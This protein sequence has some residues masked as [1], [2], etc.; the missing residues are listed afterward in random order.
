MKYVIVYLIKG[1]AKRYHEGLIKEV[2]P[3]FGENYIIENPIPSHIT[4]KS[5]FE[6]KSINKLEEILKDFTKKYK[7]SK[8]QIDGFGNFKR[9]V[10][11]LDTKFSKYTLQIQKDLIREL[12][13][14][15]IKYNKFDKKWNPHVTIAYG[16]KPETFNQIWNYL[17]TLDSPHFDLKFD[18]ITILKKPRKY[19]KIYREFELK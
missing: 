15:D 6:I 17:K 12:E 19:W 10:S 4:L 14:I 7:A 8:I 5:P 1:K 9:F 2:G 11:F 18:N 3:K 16:N 13:L